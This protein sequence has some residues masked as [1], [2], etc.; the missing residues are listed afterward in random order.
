MTEKTPKGD[1]PAGERLPLDQPAALT[2]TT[3]NGVITLTC[4]AGNMIQGA[5]PVVDDEG[6]LLA[7]YTA[8]PTPTPKSS[9][10]NNLG[11][12]IS[13]DISINGELSGSGTV[14]AGGSANGNGSFTTPNFEQGQTP[15]FTSTN[16]SSGVSGSLSGS[17]GASA[18]F[19][20][21]FRI[22]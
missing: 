6:N 19:E 1:A 15:S 18:A 22:R 13:G 17:L 20:G 12:E 8:G 10:S 11:G 5:I 7:V 16:G 9:T 3:T 2:A 21:T 4:G 14:S